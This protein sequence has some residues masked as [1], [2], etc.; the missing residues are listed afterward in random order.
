MEGEKHRIQR[1][2]MA[3]AFTSHALR[4]LAP[5]MLQKV[6]IKLSFMSFPVL[7]SLQAEELRER[8]LSI[9]DEGVGSK[10]DSI[11]AEIQEQHL[12]EDKSDVEDS[13][14]HL[15]SGSIIDVAHWV[16]RATLD[17][18]GLAGFDYNFRALE[19][20]TEEIYLAY[21]TL[22]QSVENSPGFKRIA[23]I[24]FPIIEKLLPDE[25]LRQLD[26]SRKTI[27]GRVEEIIKDK[28]E[29]IMAEI[30]TSKDIWDKD[31][32]SLLSTLRLRSRSLWLIL[33]DQYQ[34]RRISQRILRLGSP[35]QSLWTRF[36]H[37]WYVTLRFCQ[38][39]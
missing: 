3:P 12:H 18:I 6:F 4:N 37:S 13:E 30:A 39:T 36:Q 21:R 1:R 17:V 25:A 32:L 35:I 27:K 5:V 14:R 8:W 38:P 15:V 11:I 19:T 34:S 7:T 22:F 24:F 33:N 10:W 9:I 2:I 23:E 16:A 20:E 29:A 31:I 28:R 26:A